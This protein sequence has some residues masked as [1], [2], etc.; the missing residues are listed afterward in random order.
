MGGPSRQIGK[1]SRI[2]TPQHPLGIGFDPDTT[3]LHPF[4]A[5]QLKSTPLESFLVRWYQAVVSRIGA[6]GVSI[7][8]QSAFF[9]QFGPPGMIALRDISIDA[10]RRGLYVILDAKR[11]DIS[12]TMNAYGR[13]A[14]DYYQADALT[15]LPWMGTDSIQALL[16]WL[17]SGKRV[18]IVWLSSNASGRALQMHANTTRAKPIAQV[19]Y[20]QFTAIAKKEKV[21][22]QIGWVLGAT[23][24]PSKLLDE[25]PRRPH[26]FLLPGVGAQGATFGVK[27]SQILKRHPTS[28]FPVS[29]GILKMTP[30][31]KIDSWE[32]YSTAV[33]TKWLKLLKSCQESLKKPK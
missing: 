20:D 1:N 18:Y 21:L 27:T 32:A 15:V 5:K 28:I 11:G 26:H 13:A 24:L 4:L 30:D 10:K 16:P 23:D 8:L 9:E 33:E 19:V 31:I 29:R 17:K 2:K 22:D 6:P 7:K 3:E 14:F 12:S 25:L